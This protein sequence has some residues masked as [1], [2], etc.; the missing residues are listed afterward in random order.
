MPVRGGS[1]GLGLSFT[2][3]ALS[4]IR[5]NFSS[6]SSAAVF[7]GGSGFGS[8][9]FSSTFG[10]SGSL[11]FSGSF[12]CSTTASFASTVTGGGAGGGSTTGSGSGGGGSGG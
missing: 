4:R 11:G 3:F 1:T 7:F 12:G 9:F 5:R 10:F 2:S 8:G 6:R